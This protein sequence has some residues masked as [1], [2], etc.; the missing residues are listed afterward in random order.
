M[1]SSLGGGVCAGRAGVLG[2]FHP[3]GAVEALGLQMSAPNGLNVPTGSGVWPPLTFGL[4]SG[5]MKA[6]SAAKGLAGLAL[7]PP[8][9]LIKDDQPLLALFVSVFHS[10]ASC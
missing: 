5:A 9:I 3:D 6:L 8:Q 4:P 7:A 1:L 10:P 2:R